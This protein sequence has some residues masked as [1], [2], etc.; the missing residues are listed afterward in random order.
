MVKAVRDYLENFSYFLLS[1]C[2]VVFS[3][4]KLILSAFITI[5]TVT[6]LYVA[7]PSLTNIISKQQEAL[8]QNK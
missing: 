3:K 5:T 6:M 8:A 2:L 4:S 1:R 7:L